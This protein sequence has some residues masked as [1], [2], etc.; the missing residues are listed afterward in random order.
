MTFKA[1]HD[2]LGCRKQITTICLFYKCNKIYLKKTPLKLLSKNR[3]KNGVLEA[4][5]VPMDTQDNLKRIKD[6]Q[7]LFAPYFSIYV[8]SRFR[9]GNQDRCGSIGISYLP[10]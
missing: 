2:R 8:T 6:E 10:F 1:D 7:A 9:R 3:Y 5:P 4:L